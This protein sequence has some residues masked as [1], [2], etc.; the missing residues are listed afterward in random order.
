[1][2][3]GSTSSWQTERRG[4]CVPADAAEQAASGTGGDIADV[5]A[6]DLV[7][8]TTWQSST[9]MANME[10]E[11]DGVGPA[12]R[13]QKQ[14]WFPRQWRP[15]SMDL[16]AYAVLADDDIFFFSRACTHLLYPKYPYSI[17]CGYLSL[18]PNHIE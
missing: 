6:S 3:Y 15:E 4:H 18:V 14:F 11:Y 13:G 7:I 5:V 8:R 1:M 16:S 12:S 9:F 2:A 17:Q 10:T